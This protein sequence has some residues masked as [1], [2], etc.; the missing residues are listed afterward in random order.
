M[1]ILQRNRCPK[2]NFSETTAYLTRKTTINDEGAEQR[3]NLAGLFEAQGN[4]LAELDMTEECMKQSNDLS[5]LLIV[6][7]PLFFSNRITDA[8]FMAQSYLPTK[9]SETVTLWRNDLNKINHKA[10]DSLA[11]PEEYPNVFDDWLIAVAVEARATETRGNYPPASE[12]VQHAD[13]STASL[14]E[15]FRNM[16]MEEEPLENGDLDYEV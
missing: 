3:R 14:V 11:D 9:V 13:R 1:P 15:M 12:Y 5:G 2:A 8:A 10:A 7:S 16:Q 6:T 4:K